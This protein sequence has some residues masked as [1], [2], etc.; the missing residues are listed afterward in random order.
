[1]TTL[2]AKSVYVF[3]A[4]FATA[5]SS[6]VTLCTDGFVSID[7]YFSKVVMQLVDGVGLSSLGNRKTVGFGATHVLRDFSKEDKVSQDRPTTEIG[8]YIEARTDKPSWAD[9]I[10]KDE[11]ARLK[12]FAGTFPAD[13]Q[14]AACGYIAS[15]G[16]VPKGTYQFIQAGGVVVVSVDLI[17]INSEGLQLQI[18]ELASATIDT[19]EAP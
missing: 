7:C 14:K 9:A 12:A 13:I 19:C 5:A 3:L 4:C 17:L 16:P 18:A 10:G 8:W 6:E 2:A 15:Y 1:M 11:S